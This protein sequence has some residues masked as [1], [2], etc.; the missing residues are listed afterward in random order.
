MVNWFPA[1]TGF[2]NVKSILNTRQTPTETCEAGRPLGYTQP[3]C[4]VAHHV[5][6]TK[7]TLTVESDHY[8][9]TVAAP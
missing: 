9:G 1:V 8:L 3:H 5:D 4:T 7:A 6:M 2:Q